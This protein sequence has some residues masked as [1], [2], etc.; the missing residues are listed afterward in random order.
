MFVCVCV[1]RDVSRCFSIAADVDYSVN[2]VVTS[3]GR[4]T[5]VLPARFDVTCRHEFRGNVWSCPLK[6]ASWVYSGSRV[7]VSVC[8]HYLYRHQSCHS[9]LHRELVSITSRYVP[10]EMGQQSKQRFVTHPSQ[11]IR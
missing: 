7:G 3:S 1:K 8:V 10:L 9:Q 11:L 5:V 4:V 6:F 2:A